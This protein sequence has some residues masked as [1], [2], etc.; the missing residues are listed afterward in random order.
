MIRHLPASAAILLFLGACKTAELPLSPAQR[1]EKGYAFAQTITAERIRPHVFALADD[2]MAGRD[3][4]SEGEVKAALYLARHHANLGLIPVADD[5]T[6]FQGFELLANRTDGYEFT[7]TSPYRSVTLRV[8]RENADPVLV[9]A[10]APGHHDGDI[11]FAGLGITD[12]DLGIDHLAGI[13]IRGKYVLIYGDI[14]ASVTGWT[15]QRRF[16]DLILNRGAKGIIAISMMDADE[17]LETLELM[18]RGLQEPEGMRLA[19]MP[20]GGRMF[21][22]YYGITPH[23]ASELLGM[24]N[25]QAVRQRYADLGVNPRSFMPRVL[26]TRLGVY[27]RTGDAIVKSRNVAALLPGSDPDLAHEAVVLVAHYDHVGIGAPDPTGDRIHNGADDNASGTTALLAIA[28]A[29][30][31]AKKAGAGPRRSVL[32]LHVS[33]EEKGL[34]GSRYYSDHPILP[35]GN[36]VANI[37]LDMVGR[38]EEAR[39]AT[40][41]TNYVYLIGASLMS[42]KLD[43]LTTV[44]N[45]KTANLFLD[46]KLNDLNDPQQIYRRSDHWNFGRLGV[47]FV[48]FFSGL[49]DDYHRPSDSPDKIAYEVMADRIRVAYGLTIELANSDTRPLVDNQT[50]IDRTRQAP[51]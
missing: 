2:S 13:D 19:Y 16:R 43:S 33:G 18:R 26:D 15:P 23:M 44:A 32:F 41:D 1:T 36:T 35:I 10:G 50:F 29:L 31:E 48:F 39:Y 30:V 42:S 34:L 8:D 40:G 9:S 46:P 45:R 7:F 5:S 25:E 17:F 20:Q 28:D 21:F 27:G 22:Q 3:T 38:I 14:P 47:P 12:S 6:Y 11:V 49:H 4:G 24:A 37:N 51:R